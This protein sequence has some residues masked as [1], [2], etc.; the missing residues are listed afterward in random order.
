MRETALT[1]ARKAADVLAE[2]GIASARLDAELL[3]AHVLG[4]RRLD[5]YLAHDRP[6]DADELGRFRALVRRRLRR[7]P[8]QYVLGTVQFRELELAVDRRALIP[9]PETEV[10]VGEV[11]KW[12][13]AHADAHALT[14]EGQG[15]LEES[16]PRIRQVRPAAVDIGTGTGAIALSLL[17]EGPFRRL[18]ATDISGEALGLA[19]EN[20]VRSGLRERLELRAGALFEPLLPGEAFEVI[21][22]NPPYVA[23]SERG[24]LQPEVVDWEPAAALFAPGGGLGVLERLIAGAPAHLARPGLLA[25]EIGAGQAEAVV[26]R[27]RATGLY[28][29]V[30]VAPDLTGRPRVL[31]ASVG[32]LAQVKGKS[33]H[34]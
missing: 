3:L 18:V 4:V 16:D 20:A 5:L 30:R 22:S 23:E 33:D 15:R 1:L 31:L 7:E 2:S 24:G 25:L 12:A 32:S 28:E 8:L 17:R 13:Q 26:G 29:T 9:R 34:A 10:V 14:A 19:D 11:L 6:V 27:V 21:V